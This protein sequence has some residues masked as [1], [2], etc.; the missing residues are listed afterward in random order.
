MEA[1]VSHKPAKR[2]NRLPG[3]PSG[4]PVPG[5]FK[6]A[7]LTGN[8]VINSC[9]LGGEPKILAQ[10]SVSSK[11][12][13]LAK[14]QSFQ[15]NEAGFVVPEHSGKRK[16][17]NSQGISSIQ[18]SKARKHVVDPEGEQEKPGNDSTPRALH[19]LSQALL[20]QICHRPCLQTSKSSYREN[21]SC[22]STGS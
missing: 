2:P 13:Y 19:E 1:E 5:S 18:V 4:Q 22:Q 21:I 9:D 8:E 12:D 15:F 3:I 14:G 10:V 7:Y 6:T 17:K 11:I 16:D 20:P